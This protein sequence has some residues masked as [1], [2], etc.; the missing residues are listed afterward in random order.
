MP[1]AR[2]VPVAA[3]AALLAGGCSAPAPA[4][5]VVG[6]PTTS[7]AV[8]TTAATTAPATP[9]A[10]TPAPV[11]GAAARCGP[12]DLDAALGA[13]EGPPEQLVVRVVWTNTGDGP[14][15]MTGFGGA[16]LRDGP[17]T[18]SLP[19]AVRDA[20]PVRLAPGDRAH[21]T[22]TFLPVAE[23]D[24]GAFRPTE[25][26]VTPPDGTTSTALPWTAGP[27]LRQDGATRPGTYLGPVEPGA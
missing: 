10:T 26:V 14:C 17:D 19:R 5:G 8:P 2:A 15:T 20:A 12:A 18:I 23:G 16:D 1:L 21:G 9:A 22:I 11:T 3:L 7:A 13:P 25:V 6:P 4:E 24:P 27:V